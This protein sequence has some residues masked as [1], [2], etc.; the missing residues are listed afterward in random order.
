MG[1][2]LQPS[3]IAPLA[4]VCGLESMDRHINWE[5]QRKDCLLL[6]VAVTVSSSPTG[7]QGRVKGERS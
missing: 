7:C 5:Q 1:S 2:L 4:C 3:G 6:V